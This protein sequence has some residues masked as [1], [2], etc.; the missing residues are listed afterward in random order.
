MYKHLGY[1]GE[2]LEVNIFL[3]SDFAKCRRYVIRIRIKWL[4]ERFYTDTFTD[5][6]Y[7]DT[8]TD[9]KNSPNV[10]MVPFLIRKRKADT[11]TDP[12]MWNRGIQLLQI[13]FVLKGLLN[14]EL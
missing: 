11:D 8:D 12:E 14:G 4:T 9:D 3:S 6:F 5:E 2:N 1:I 7:P 10:K 13:M